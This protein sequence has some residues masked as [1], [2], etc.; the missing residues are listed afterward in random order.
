VTHV[1]LNNTFA[2][3]YHR[4]IP[5]RSLGDHMTALK[6]YRAAVADLLH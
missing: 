5:G 2:R 1:T 3:Y 4:R 6:R